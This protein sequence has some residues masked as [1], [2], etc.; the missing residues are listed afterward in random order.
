M[1]SMCLRSK[2]MS[3]AASIS[4]S[5]PQG[6]DMPGPEGTLSCTL[7]LQ[8]VHLIRG[9]GTMPASRLLPSTEAADL[10]ALVKEIAA[11]ELAPRV[12]AFE[13]EELFPREVF[14]TLGRAGLLGLAYPEAL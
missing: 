2:A 7:V 10:I 14:R 4:M 8:K 9:R 3:A 6:E 5:A 11:R 13:R 1:D 12:D